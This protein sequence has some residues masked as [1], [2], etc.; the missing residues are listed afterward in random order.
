MILDFQH[1]DIYSN[2]HPY[3]ENV[4]VLGPATDD[5]DSRYINASPII[6]IYGEPSSQNLMIAA[7]GPLDWTVRHFW[8]LVH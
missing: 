7:Q 3:K 1:M 2:V 8:K 6:S 5:P 4:C